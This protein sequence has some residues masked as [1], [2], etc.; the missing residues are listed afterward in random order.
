MLILAITFTNWTYCS[1]R[2]RQAWKRGKDGGEVDVDRWGKGAEPSHVLLD[3]R[4]KRNAHSRLNV[5]PHA[6]K[7]RREFSQPCQKLHSA[8]LSSKKI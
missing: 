1:P 3:R 2:P 4:R 6:H 7:E 5:R 8:A